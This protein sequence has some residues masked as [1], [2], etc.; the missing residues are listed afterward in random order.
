[1]RRLFVVLA[2]TL[3][4][5]AATAH[6]A[7][8]D[9]PRTLD[10]LK[11]RIAG[12]LARTHVPGVGL[13]LV[14]RDRV[15]WAGGVGLADRD[16]G[17]PVTADTMFRVGSITKSFVSL[18][19][20]KLSEEGRISLDARVADL[21]PEL[22]IENRWARQAPITVAHLC[23]HT[24]GFDDMHF[25]E[26][27]APLAVENAPLA[28]I[29]ARNPRSR[30]A[31]WAPGSR[32]SY[33]NPGYTVAAYLLE[34]ASG[35]R[36]FD[37]IRD[38]LL[39]P[40]GMT[41]ASLRWTPAV[42]AQLARGYDDGPAA[43]PYRAIYHVPAGN[44]MASPR[45]LAALVR[46]WLGRGAVDGRAL[47]SRAGVERTERSETNAVR[48]LDIDYGLGN[49][50]GTG[51]VIERGHDGGIDGFIS[52]AH[53][54]PARGV[55]YVVLINSTGRGAGIAI[56]DIRLLVTQYLVGRAS[57]PPPAVDVPAAEL[58]GWVG[59]YHL[60]NPR[61]QLF[62][63]LQRLDGDFVVRFVDGKLVVDDPIAHKTMKLVP[64][65]GGR[66]RYEGVAGSHIALSRDAAGRRV[67]FNWGIYAVEEPAWWA[68]AFAAA[69]RAIVWLLLSALALPIAAVVLWRQGGARVGWL[70]PTLSAFS[71]FAVPVLFFRAA[72]AHALGERNS[73]TVGICALTIAFA[74][75]A[76]LGS[77]RALG[78]LGQ[79]LPLVVRL[80]RLAVALAALSAT[81]FFAYY[82]ILGIRL[83]SY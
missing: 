3:A 73:C 32:F 65:G 77:L 82:R 40:L 48:G 8:L 34:K 14:T 79:P 6:G 68:P 22:S 29:L 11:A 57:A 1:M 2:V 38:E 56:R 28:E 58:R 35:R 66:F 81:V 67:F 31:R 62:A 72:E 36:W 83:W 10:E 55:G 78:G 24:A 5:R 44:L 15:L 50:G 16:A 17:R 27:Y 54:V 37:Y 75:G 26:F 49:Y 80:H 47:V 52:S 12:V 20:V 63:F 76:I 21:A 19:L 64:L 25:N 23:E 7:A 9:R 59:A 71:F 51:P 61:M 60:A 41:H 70:W 43:I 46:L 33:A 13:A 42:D 18:A 53:Y 39:V 30:V 4:L 45:E 69:A 74:A